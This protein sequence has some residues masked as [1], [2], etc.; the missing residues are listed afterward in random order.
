MLRQ[1]KH[2]RDRRRAKIKSQV[3]GSAHR[4]RLSIFRSHRH[5]LAQLI[6]DERGQTLLAGSDLDQEIKD[7]VKG[8]PKLEIAGLVGQFLA[9]KAKEQKIGQVVFDRAGYRYHG[10]VKAVVEAF[11]EGGVKI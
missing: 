8:K 1:Y 6:D 11:R 2:L 3:W 4:P 5:L 9:K 7:R 10:R